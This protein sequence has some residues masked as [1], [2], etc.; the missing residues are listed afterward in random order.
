MAS[1]WGINGLTRSTGIAK[2]IPCPEAM[3]AVVMPTISPFMLNKGPPEF[4]G[5]IGAS[6]WMKSS[7]GPAPM[8]RPLALTIPAVTV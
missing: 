1:S 3:M 2:P 7:Y 6:V 5:L 8:M 4:P